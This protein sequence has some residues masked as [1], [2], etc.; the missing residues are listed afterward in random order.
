MTI[1]W[2]KHTILFFLLFALLLSNSFAQTK[3]I[4]LD[5]KSSD[6]K[7]VLRALADQEGVNLVIDNEVSGIITVQLNKVTFLQALNIIT[8]NNNLTYTKTDNLYRISPVDNSLLKIEFNEG[9][10]SLEAREVK[11]SKLLQELA[12]QTG[13]NLVPGPDLQEK[14]TIR[15]H[16][17]PLRDALDSLLIQANCMEEK[18]GKVSFIRKKSTPALSFTVNFQNNLLTV[19]AKNIPVAALCRS[20]SEKSGVSVVPDQNLAAN[21]TVFFQDLTVDDGLNIMCETNGLQLYQEGKARRITRKSGAYRIVTTKNQLSV[22]AD[23]VDIATILREISRQTGINIAQDRDIRGNITA[24]FQ[25]LPLAQGLVMLVENQ[26]WVVDKQSNQYY[27]RTNTNQNKN[28]RI[29]YN[30]DNELFD[31]DV[32]NAPVATVI[33]EMARRANLDIVILSQVNWTVNNIRLQKLKFT[34]ILDF[35]FKG[36]IFS[37]KQVNE[38]FLIGDGLQIRPENKDFAEVKIYQIKYVKAEQLLNSLPPIFPRQNF[39][40]LAEKNALILSAPQSIHDLFTDY[41]S[42][43]DVATI[44]DRTEVIKVKYLKAEDMLKLIPPSLPKSDLIVV[45]EANAIVVSGPQNVINQVKSYIEKIDQVN[46]LI[47]FDIMVVQISNSNGINWE[48]PKGVIKLPNGK[49]LLVSPADPSITLSKPG[50]N[51]STTIATLNALVQKGQAKILANPTITTLNGYQASFNV[52]TKYNYSVPSTVSEDGKTITE[53]VKTYDSGLYFTIVPW[54]SV[55]KQITMEIKPK[56]SEFGDSPKGSTLP[57]TSERSTETTVRVN[58]GQTII[59]SGLKNSRKQNSVSK[60]P[61]LGHIPILGYLFTNRTVTETQDEFVLVITPSLVFDE[62]DQIKVNHQVQEKMG[63]EM[64][65]ELN[66][67]PVSEDGKGKKN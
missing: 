1:K 6:I 35:L 29:S 44:E 51:T 49:E 18:V 53:S 20:I 67:K 27:V 13:A 55:N 59:I 31:L 30:P 48:A 8:T 54:V 15:I 3:P 16:Q 42:Q 32:Q 21:L 28:I 4:S 22:D 34:A 45:K 46:P 14:V 41:L 60:V 64:K 10:L 50:T 36:T 33:S 2:L 5:F 63:A 38:V 37:F 62:A 17:T 65:K 47:V 9:I 19:D 7:D 56:I 39:T 52:S 61:L 12:Q 11:L 58:D 43:V 57:S 25:N 23:N 26:G 24:H 40:Q 66:P